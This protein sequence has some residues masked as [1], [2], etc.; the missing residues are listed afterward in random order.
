VAEELLQRLLAA[1]R[2]EE[3]LMLLDHRQQGRVTQPKL[4]LKH[5][6]LVG[7]EG[8]VREFEVEKPVPGTSR[9]VAGAIDE[10]LADVVGKDRVLRA[11]LV[12]LNADD[13]DRP[14]V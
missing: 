12:A 2:G 3:L 6:G 7:R 11:E 4:L 8:A 14:E 1:V 9:D 10:M 5:G 13:V